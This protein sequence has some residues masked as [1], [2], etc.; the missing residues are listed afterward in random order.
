MQEQI[1]LNE[2]EKA[3]LH[4]EELTEKVNYT[5]NHANKVVEENINSGR[6]VWDGHMAEFY[7][8][9]WE[10]LQKEFPSIL[11]TFNEQEKNLKEYL[12]NMKKV[13]SV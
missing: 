9:R 4:L 10:T 7:K 6:G 5:L 8:R 13:E 1:N 11:E 12:E 3:V 2:L